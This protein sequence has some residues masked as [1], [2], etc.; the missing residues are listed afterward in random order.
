[1]QLIIGI[2]VLLHGLVHMWFV[3]L[4]QGW[5]EFQTDMGWTG[6]SW[7]LTNWMG[8]D[9][10]KNAATT[11][12]GLATLLYLVAG[13]GLLAKQ[14]W[15]QPWMIGASIVSV[16]AILVFWDGNFSLLV[17]KGLLGFLI[18]VGLLVAALVFKW[19][20]A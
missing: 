19:P 1:M 16:V 12:Y 17:Q 3:T 20:A 10:I 8:Q 18:S 6:K 7:L 14:N 5:V 15:T 2:F 9:L 13:I 11:M 4:S